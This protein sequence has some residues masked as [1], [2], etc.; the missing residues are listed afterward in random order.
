M[1]TAD[2]QAVSGKV[3][4]E[5]TG[6]AVAGA[7]VF[8]NNSSIGT[9]TAADGSFLLNTIPP[10]KY[11]LI[12]SAVGYE[13]LIYTIGP[14]PVSRKLRFEMRTKVTEMQNVVVGGYVTET[15]EKWGKTFLET[16]LGVTPIARQCTIKNTKALRFRFYKKQ[17]LLEVV[18][19]EPLQ[20]DNALLGYVLQYDLQDFKM[21]FRAHSSYF[22]GYTLFK[23]KRNAAKK[24]I[25]KRR[26]DNY[27]G[28][29]MHFMR[30][31]YAGKIADEGFR[32]RRMTR[33]CNLEKERVR[34]LFK[35]EIR[36]GKDITIAPKDTLEP[37]SSSYYKTILQQ[38]DY[39]DVY[40]SWLLTADSI[41][42]ASG[43][44]Q[45][46]AYW[47]HYLAITYMNATEAPEYLQ[48]TGEARKPV[49][50]FSLLQLQTRQPLVIDANGN[51]SPPESLITSGYW[52]WS[53]KVANMLPLDYVP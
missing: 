15:W 19:D 21:D 35:K 1:Y 29:T 39:E 36:L 5:G 34:A 38:K 18:A 53:D 24:A 37:D 27:L 44:G 31:L 40:S 14:E 52:S 49:P 25:K 13:T 46:P 16:F 30:S 43:Q 3:V 11:D 2:A 47:E 10:G 9:V 32:V 33:I 26:R 45:R 48:Y 51:W 41:L 50:R 4:Q 17:Q 22:A 8:I 20:I 7:S 23:D 6:E 42:I 28:S 12:V